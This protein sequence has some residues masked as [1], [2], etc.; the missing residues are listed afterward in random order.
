MSRSPSAY[1]HRS[2]LRDND[3]FDGI[4][5]A[6][7]VRELM[8]DCQK[9]GLD[10]RLWIEAGQITLDMPPLPMN[11]PAVCYTV[12]KF[13]ILI[14][15]FFEMNLGLTTQYNAIQSICVKCFYN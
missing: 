14:S 3:A 4:P 1:V 7:K 12:N 13:Y 2:K 9:D 10:C 6:R 5:S 15:Q 8:G 11:T